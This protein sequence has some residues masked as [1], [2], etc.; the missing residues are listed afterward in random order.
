MA[1]PLG[2]SAYADGVETQGPGFAF[3]RFS[4]RHA[5][6]IVGNSQTGR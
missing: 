5:S 2:D 6:A 3:Y 1:D 4:N